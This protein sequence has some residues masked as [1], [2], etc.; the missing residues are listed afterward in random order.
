MDDTDLIVTQ[1]K[2]LE[3][4]L[5]VLSARIQSPSG[6][7]VRPT[8]SF[9]ELYGKLRGQV[10]SSEEEIDGVLYQLPASGEDYD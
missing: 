10:V 2:S 7:T 8:H 3:A 4:Q 1:I 5:R 6:P 9:A